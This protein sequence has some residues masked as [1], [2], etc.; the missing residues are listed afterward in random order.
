MSI[1][2]LRVC[3]LYILL[4]HASLLLWSFFSSHRSPSAW[5]MVKY[6]ARLLLISCAT[7]AMHSLRLRTLGHPNR[8]EKSPPH[9]SVFTQNIVCCVMW[10]RHYYNAS[11]VKDDMVVNNTA[12]EGWRLMSHYQVGPQSKAQTPDPG[13][14]IAGSKINRKWMLNYFSDSTTYW[15][16]NKLFTLFI[17]FTTCNH[18][19]YYW[20]NNYVYNYYSS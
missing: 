1:D 14:H 11:D 19:K 2:I 10:F 5:L 3:S 12:H 20:C 7:R 6:V 17:F 15:S 9:W 13:L 16:Q 18:P 4:C 8:R